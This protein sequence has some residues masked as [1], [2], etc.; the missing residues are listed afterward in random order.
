MKT[1]ASLVTSAA[2]FLQNQL[3]MEGGIFLL[4]FEALCKDVHMCSPAK[5]GLGIQGKPRLYHLLCGDY[6]IIAS[7]ECFLC[8]WHRA[9]HFN[10]YDGILTTG[11]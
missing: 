10:T 9:E 6:I 2:L 8:I 11:S 5:H 4:T 1:V 3:E 7:P